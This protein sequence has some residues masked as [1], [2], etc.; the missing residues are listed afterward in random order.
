MPKFKNK[1][2]YLKWNA[3]ISIIEDAKKDQNKLKKINVLFIVVFIALTFSSIAISRIEISIEIQGDEKETY[4]Q[5]QSDNNKLVAQKPARKEEGHSAISVAKIEPAAITSPESGSHEHSGKLSPLISH[6]IP[7]L[8]EIIKAAKKGVV[9]ISSGNS[10]GSGFII[11]ESGDIITNSHVLGKNSEV[12]IKLSSGDSYVGRVLKKGVPP[13]DIALLK[14]DISD[15]KDY[16]PLNKHSPCQAGAEVLAIG[17]PR[18]LKYTVTKGIVSNC[19]ILDP[20]FHEIKYIQT[21]TAISPGNSG[22]PL[23]NNQGEVLGVN[24][25][26]LSNS[27]SIG[28]A[29]EID[30][31]KAFIQNKLTKVEADLQRIKAAK[32]QIEEERVQKSI[33]ELVLYFNDVWS[34]E[35]INYMRAAHE[36]L[37][38]EARRGAYFNFR[39]R[40]NAMIKKKKMPPAA[41]GFSDLQGWFEALADQAVTGDLTVDQATENIKKHLF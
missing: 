14:I 39:E 32:V 31:V 4:T 19:D 35:L 7:P 37:E 36:R 23:I 9:M 17:Q 11:S 40:Y 20:N 27:E 1:E 26:I 12:R 8:T 2:E 15:Y 5:K 10:L 33:K 29:I 28:F 22:G 24:T 13:L 25:L 30:T 3:N 38:M 21:D 6:P 18:G 41:S 16:L 34:L